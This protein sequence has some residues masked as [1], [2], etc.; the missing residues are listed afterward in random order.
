MA[1]VTVIVTAS[2]P[3]PFLYVTVRAVAASAARARAAGH[4]LN[5]VV[6][7]DQP[8]A[9]TA[10]LLRRAAPLVSTVSTIAS[11]GRIDA[12]CVGAAR[13]H[14]I[15]AGTADTLFFHQA[16]ELVSPDYYERF[17]AF[18]ARARSDGLGEMVLH[19]E[20]V[21]TYG[22][23]TSVV[24]SIRSDDSM[25]DP[26]SL[27]AAPVFSSMPMCGRA[28]VEASP[29]AGRDAGSGIGE[30]NWRWVAETLGR[31]VPHLF[32]PETVGFARHA[33]PKT[34]RVM[35]RSILFDPLTVREESRAHE[36]T[37]QTDWGDPASLLR[38]VSNGYDPIDR[39]T[40]PVRALF[41]EHAAAVAAIEPALDVFAP[42][43]KLQPRPK[44]PPFLNGPALAWRTIAVRL[45]TKPKIAVFIE[46]DML[47]G[48]DRVVPRLIID[49][50]EQAGET[51]QV[52]LIH[53]LGTLRVPWALRSEP[54]LV[55]VDVDG[56][57]ARHGCDASI[58]RAII[59]RLF[60]QT[61]VV[62]IHDCG[63][64]L[65][66]E[67]AEVHAD[68]L[69]RYAGA[70]ALLDLT[71]SDDVLSPARL[72]IARSLAALGTAGPPRVVTVSEGARQAALVNGARATL[73]PASAQAAL[74]AL[75]RH[76]FRTPPGLRDGGPILQPLEHAVGP[77][78]MSSAAPVAGGMHE[79]GARVLDDLL[80]PDLVLLRGE[81]IHLPLSALTRIVEAMRANGSV[82]AATPQILVRA[83]ES[84]HIATRINPDAVAGSLDAMRA[85][86][87]AGVASWPLL[88]V[89][90]RD[91]LGSDEPSVTRGSATLSGISVHDILLRLIRDGLP[92]MPV[93]DAVTFGIA[94]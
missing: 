54:R 31:G 69:A 83:D 39:H 29:M 20:L 61:A 41:F 48:A 16:G 94:R 19:P 12:G 66:A 67:F 43:E 28:V 87:M 62:A 51:H 57:L 64:R 26:L 86:R 80:G 14:A 8:D 1:E 42:A 60:V 89:A 52:L 36:A 71:S 53:R 21:A 56:L 23:A 58:A 47:Q 34:R 59:A 3:A 92:V 79:A 91:K 73:L 65:F 10:R 74:T 38:S 55:A 30:D 85:E 68:L 46:A 49:A 5:I 40:L 15:N 17:L 93:R 76:R 4:V 75:R 81:D 33:A 7:A 84:G 72:A 82:A 6:V 18:A 24:R 90:R 78:A 9:Q 27:I 32:V 25:F 2:G 63:S 70:T 11:P 77:V 37:A 35:G 22:A 50:L 13:Q 45:N 88:A 44:L